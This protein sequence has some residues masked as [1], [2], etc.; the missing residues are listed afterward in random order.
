MWIDT[1]EN[2]FGEAT[3]FKTLT[4]IEPRGGNDSA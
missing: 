3:E 2:D 1:N 4:R